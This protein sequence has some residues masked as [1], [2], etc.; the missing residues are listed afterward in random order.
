M[1]IETFSNFDNDLSTRLISK[2]TKVVY[3]QKE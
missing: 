3:L 2:I 1:P